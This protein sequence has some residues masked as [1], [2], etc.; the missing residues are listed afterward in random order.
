LLSNAK[1]QETMDDNEEVVSDGS[2]L[3]QGREALNRAVHGDVVAV[4][5]LPRDQWKAPLDVAV[6]EGACGTSR[7]L[8]FSLVCFFFFF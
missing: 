1:I 6:E 7:S 3:I 4:Q 5:L 2:V 8:F